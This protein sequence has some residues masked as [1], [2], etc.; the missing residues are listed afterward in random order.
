MTAIKPSNKQSMAK[1]PIAATTVI[2]AEFHTGVTL[3]SKL[4]GGRPKNTS[5]IT[6]HKSK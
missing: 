2:E 6:W 1:P 4:R 3:A 5:K